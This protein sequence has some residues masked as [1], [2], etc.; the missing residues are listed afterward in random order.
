MAGATGAVNP[1]HRA[2]QRQA[3]GAAALAVSQQLSISTYAGSDLPRHNL[4]R[5]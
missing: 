5:S 1:G 3:R 4:D 2:L